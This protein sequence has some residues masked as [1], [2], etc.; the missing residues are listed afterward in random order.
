MNCSAFVIYLFLP[1]K[2]GKW[3]VKKTYAIFVAKRIKL[4]SNSFWMQIPSSSLFAQSAGSSRR[5]T[6]VSSSR[7]NFPGSEE[8]QRSRPG[9]I[10][11]GVIPRTSPVEAAKRSSSSTRRHFESAIK[12][13]DNLQVSDEHHPHWYINCT[14]WSMTFFSF[15][16]YY[17]TKI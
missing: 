1:F 15:C 10:S 16:L 17:T 14:T 4:S 9:D 2:I 3:Y 7:D 6:A 13:I 11:R 8:F 5:V 12:G